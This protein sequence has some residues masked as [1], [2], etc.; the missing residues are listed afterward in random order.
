L[1][2]WTTILSLLQSWL[3][4]SALLL[5]TIPTEYAAAATVLPVILAAFSKRTAIFLGT[6]LLAV[7]ALILLLEPSFAAVTIA[8]GAYIG[9]LIAAF[10]GIQ[11][12]RKESATEAE[13]ANIR[14]ELKNLVEAEERRFLVELKSSAKTTEENGIEGPLR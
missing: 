6:A 1:E 8:I 7:V 14:S 3:E 5:R 12:R 4:Q 10:L 9:S 13:L 11:A 2:T